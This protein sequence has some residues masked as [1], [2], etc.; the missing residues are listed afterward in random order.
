LLV[1][2]PVPSTHGP[3]A[4]A[5]ALAEAHAGRGARSALLGRHLSGVLRAGDGRAGGLVD[6]RTCKRLLYLWLF[7]GHNDGLNVRATLECWPRV[8]W[9]EVL[10]A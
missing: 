1:S 7:V 4:L 9:S 3:P 8:R 5:G 2:A 6:D 10:G